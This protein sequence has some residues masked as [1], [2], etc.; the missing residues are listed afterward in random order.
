MQLFLHI[1]RQGQRVEESVKDADFYASDQIVR[2]GVMSNQVT[3]LL[4]PIILMIF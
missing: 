4:L 3:K 1:Y 2:F